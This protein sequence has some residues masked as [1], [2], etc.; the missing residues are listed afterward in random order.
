M[1]SKWDD[2]SWQKDFLNTDGLNNCS[3]TL[4][5]KDMSNDGLIRGSDPTLI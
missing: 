5:N 2:T 4:R 1:S 3:P